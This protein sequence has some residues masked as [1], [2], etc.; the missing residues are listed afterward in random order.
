MTTAPFSACR[1][2]SLLVTG[3]KLA[4]QVERHFER[5]VEMGVLVRV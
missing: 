3:G 2:R 1:N 4:A 5:L